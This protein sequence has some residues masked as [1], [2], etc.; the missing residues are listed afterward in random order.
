[1][2]DGN[3]VLGRERAQVRVTRD[4]M[5]RAQVRSERYEKVCREPVPDEALDALRGGR[6]APGERD[7]RHVRFQHEPDEL[8]DLGERNADLRTA[9]D[10]QRADE[11]GVRVV[12]ERLGLVTG[13]RGDLLLDMAFLERDE[14]R[15]LMLILFHGIS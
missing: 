8:E 1:M 10:R 6:L 9:R 13:E 4:V 12:A 2:V 15:R 7:P 14:R 3:A 11:L 5:A